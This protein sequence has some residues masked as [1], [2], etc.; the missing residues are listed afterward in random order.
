M[1]KALELRPLGRSERRLLRQ[2]LRDLS[3]SAKVHQRYRIIEQVRRGFSLAETADRVGR[4]F[5]VAC[6]WVHH[7]NQGGF[8]R[9]EQ[10]A[11]PHGRPPILRAA[12]LRDLVDVALSNP[13]ERGL[14]FSDWSVAKLADYCRQRRLLPEVTDEWVRRLLRRKGLTAQRIRTWKTSSDPAYDR[15]KN[16]PCALSGTPP[17]GGRSLLRRVGTLGIEAHGRYGLGS[18]QARRAHA[19][20]LSP[21]EGNG[22]VS[23]LL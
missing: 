14:P 18:A 4:H 19:R 21:Q 5:T 23:G 10:V 7:F 9:F 12:Q 13:Q 6:D 2:K 3:L 20:H 17:A 11:N 8:S 15:K 1:P 22:A 16:H